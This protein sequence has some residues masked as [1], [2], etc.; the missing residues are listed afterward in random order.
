LLLL[1]GIISR[2]D[3]ER[4]TGLGECECIISTH[5]AAVLVGPSPRRATADEGGHIGKKATVAVAVVAARVAPRNARRVLQ[6]RRR[7]ER[8]GRRRS[9]TM[10]IL[11]FDVHK[12]TASS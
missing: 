4:R 1:L 5:D 2:Y 9:R 12:S 3:D 10:M 7:M 8:L 6:A 11:L